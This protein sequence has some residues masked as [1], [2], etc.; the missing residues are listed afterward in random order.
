MDELVKKNINYIYDILIDTQDYMQSMYNPNDASEAWVLNDINNN[1][2]KAIRRIEVIE[3]I[4]RHQ[5]GHW[6]ED[7]TGYGYWTCSVCG[8]VT[9]ASV[10]NILYHYCPNCGSDMR[11]R[12]E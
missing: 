6:I 5:K 8:F 11:M 2:N 1:M 10:A 12:G 3:E 7:E 9:E 4:L